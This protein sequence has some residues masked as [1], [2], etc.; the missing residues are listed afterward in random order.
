MQ[1]KKLIFLLIFG[2]IFLFVIMSSVNAAVYEQAHNRILGTTYSSTDEQGMKITIGGTGYYLHNVTKYQTLTDVTRVL[3]K[4]EN[5]TTIATSTNLE[6]D[7]FIFYPT[8]LYLLPSTNYRIELDA[9]GGSHLNSYNS[10]AGFGLPIVDTK[11]TWLIRSLNGADNN[12]YVMNIKSIYLGDIPPF[13]PPNI[14]VSLIS[15]ENKSSYVS[16]SINFNVNFSITEINLVNYTWKNSTYFFWYDNGTLFDSTTV[17]L[18]SE[19]QTNYTL[20]ESNFVFGNYSYNS[21]GCYGN[22]TYSNCV[23]SEN[24]N[25]SF[26]VSS[27]QIENIQYNSATV[28]SSSETFKLI[29][30]KKTSVSSISAY[31]WY[32]GIP[33]VSTV[34]KSGNNFNITNT[35]E[36]PSGEGGN[37]SFFWQITATG[38]EG[39]QYINSSSYNQTVGNLSIYECTGPTPSGLTLNFTLYDSLSNI[40]NGS[41]ES[42]FEYY[43]YGGSG[44]VTETFNFQSI[45]ENKSNW[46]FCLNSSGLN[47]SFDGFVS[48]YA[49][50]YDRREY[51]FDDAIIGNFTQNIPLYLS[52][53]ADT[54]VVTI[55]AKDQNY[56]PLVG[57]L[58]AIQEWNVGTNTYSTIGMFYTDS[59]GNGIMNLELYNIWYRVIVTYEGEIVKVTDVQK[60]ADT[61]W[62]IIVQLQT[63]NPYELFGSI[64]HGLV[65]DNVTNITTFS[66][67]DNSGYINEGCL[68]IKNKTNLGYSTIYEECTTTVAGTIN[69]QIVGDGDYEII[70]T[71]Y[72]LPIY[73]VSQVTDSLY[74]RLGIPQIVST[75]SPFGKV[76]SFI[77]I[78]TSASIGVAAS[79]PIWGAILLIFSIW[80]AGKMGWLNITEQIFWSLLSIVVVI[81]LRQTKK[82]T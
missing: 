8:I 45:N 11:I 32:N 78:G 59:E 4:W 60:L 67:V 6:G 70:G 3:I 50:N 65:F 33:Y 47:V 54:D 10:T 2:M 14:N 34:T 9:E 72:L 57:A 41:F 25:F 26:E 40:I 28:E 75:V 29:G 66:W 63:E 35:I 13:V 58:V 16:S 27:I 82:G 5:G 62:P 7:T 17:T 20:Q 37:K 79:N 23:W 64:S 73:N 53:I 56:N 42:T 52:L 51:I 68:E 15:P 38:S 24:G 19:N 30:T 46:M 39:T 36:I 69:Y 74:I 1:R 71:I 49:E 22:S 12:A 61:T 55:T 43:A 81:I 76:L 21:Y 80:G 77:F 18:P 48:Y 31:F 44:L